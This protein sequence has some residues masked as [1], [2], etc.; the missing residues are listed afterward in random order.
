MGLVRLLLIYLA[1]VMVVTVGVVWAVFEFNLLPFHKAEENPPQIESL[2]RI[3][4]PETRRETRQ[5]IDQDAGAMAIPAYE[6]EGRQF[7]A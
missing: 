2:R 6:L 7:K 5:A 1:A 3:M 4:P